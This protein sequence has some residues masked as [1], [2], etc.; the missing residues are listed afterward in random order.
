[1]I[2]PLLMAK[3]RGGLSYDL[4]DAFKKQMVGG[5]GSCVPSNSLRASTGWPNT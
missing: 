4:N 3:L 1:M 2:P 5:A